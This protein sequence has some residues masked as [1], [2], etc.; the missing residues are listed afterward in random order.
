MRAVV[1]QSVPFAAAFAFACARPVPAQIQQVAGTASCRACVVS[2]QTLHRFSTD[3]TPAVLFSELYALDAR[4]RLLVVDNSQHEIR[5][6]RAD[7]TLSHIIGRRG[8]GPGEFAGAVEAWIGLA[9]TVIVFDRASRRLS[10]FEPERGRF[11][12]S[13][14]FEWKIEAVAPAGTGGDLFVVANIATPDRAGLPLHLVSAGGTLKRS[15]AV[16]SLDLL[17][18][19]PPDPTERVLARSQDRNCVW[20]ASGR[21]YAIEHVCNDGRVQ[22][23]FT[24]GPAWF[25]NTPRRTNESRGQLPRTDT[26]ITSIYEDS[27]RR[28]W[29]FATSTTQ[30]SQIPEMRPGDPGLDAAV[31]RAFRGMSYVEVIDLAR[32]DLLASFG[33]EV[34]A[35]PLRADFWLVLR[36]ERLELSRALLVDSTRSGR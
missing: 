35:V 9:D 32:G 21:T 17:P 28:L 27:Q 20:T 30:H 14:L 13:I 22:K 19:L 26:R 7:G 29:V 1:R 31:A 4:D 6:L 23:R 33:R 11:I 15:F 2:L 5:V 16:T 8:G 18:G 12:R 36:D 3:D 24:R 10:I 25:T 34:A